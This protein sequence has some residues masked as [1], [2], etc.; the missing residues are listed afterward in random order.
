MITNV[1]PASFVEILPKSPLLELG[2]P[3]ALPGNI[4]EECQMSRPLVRIV[5]ILRRGKPILLFELPH[6]LVK[7][8]IIY[9][10]THSYL[11]FVALPQDIYRLAL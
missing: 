8:P 1:S 4:G 9:Q 5:F 6:Q 10:V 11:G 7:R 3:L 2:D